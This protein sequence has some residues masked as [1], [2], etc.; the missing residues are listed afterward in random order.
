MT[1]QQL[2]ERVNLTL[3]IASIVGLLGSPIAA[4]IAASREVARELG[5]ITTKL[6][7]HGKAMD[8]YQREAETFRRELAELRVADKGLAPIET[9]LGQVERRVEDHEVRLRAVEVK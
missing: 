9:R 3:K 7:E 1:K 5:V 6:E 2:I 8:T 4:Y